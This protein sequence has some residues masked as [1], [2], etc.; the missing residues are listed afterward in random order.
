MKLV[1]CPKCNS[2][3]KIETEKFHGFDTIYFAKCSGCG[4]S[5]DKALA[6]EFALARFCNQYSVV[7]K[8][9]VLEIEK[10]GG[11]SSNI[12][13]NRVKRG[14]YPEAIK[15][16]RQWI[17]P[18]K[19][20]EEII[21]EWKQK[22]YMTTLE[23]VTAQCGL[24]KKALCLL[25]ELKKIKA[26]LIYGK[27]F[28]DKEEAERLIAYYKNS[29]ETKEFA[30]ARFYN[31][32][33]V[34]QNI[35]ITEIEKNG[36]PKSKTMVNRI[37]HGT[38]PEAIKEKRKWVFP[39]KKAE[40]IIQEYQQKQYMIPLGEVT[41]RCGLRERSLCLLAKQGKIKATLI[42]GKWFVDKEEVERLITYYKYSITTTEAAKKLNL[43]HRI[44][45]LKKIKQGLIPAI[46]VG[47]RSRVPLSYFEKKKE[48]DDSN[49]SL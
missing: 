31:Q 36:G 22:Q 14:F 34:V 5:G 40:K 47:I 46:M 6:K 7:Q 37:N 32:Y 28:V 42:C 26:T 2:D 21:Q 8:M 20:A 3:I 38:Y 35:S 41:S 45:I 12:I 1:K 25:A 48:E 33:N 13:I 24:K 49:R 4:L 19:R 18:C 10:N 9:S 43:C 44:M 16:K 30:L 39:F 27:W 15:E 17:L 23:E 29:I 11:P